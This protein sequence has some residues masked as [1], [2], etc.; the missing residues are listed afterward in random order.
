MPVGALVERAR[1]GGAVVPVSL[2]NAKP[3][4]TVS[5]WTEAALATADAQAGKAGALIAERVLL[6]PAS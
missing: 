2:A 6:A 3:G 5:L 1:Q 4:E